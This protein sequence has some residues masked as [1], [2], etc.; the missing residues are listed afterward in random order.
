M[1]TRFNVSNFFAIGFNSIMWTMLQ[2]FFQGEINN[3]T[4]NYVSNVVLLQN[5]KMKLWLQANFFIKKWKP[6]WITNFKVSE[7]TKNIYIYIL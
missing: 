5:M 7:T 3:V 6:Q 4:V 1:L 2:G